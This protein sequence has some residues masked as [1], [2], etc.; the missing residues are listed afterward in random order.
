MSP[1]PQK[2]RKQIDQLPFYKVCSK[3]CVPGHTCDG[4][5][6][7]EHTIIFGGKQLQELWAIIPIC[8]FGHSVN[9]HQDGGDLNK[10][11]NLWIALSRALPKELMNISKATNYIRELNRLSLKYGF[12]TEQMAIDAY[13]NRTPKKKDAVAMWF[14]LSKDLKYMVNLIQRNESLYIG[15]KQGPFD[16]IIKA[17]KEYHEKVLEE[18][19]THA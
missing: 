13:I 3:A 2:I 11:I 10:E 18:V 14:P 6:T 1:I 5:I 12:Y 4:K 17:I 19:K 16:I 9:K 15:L 7:M 8:E